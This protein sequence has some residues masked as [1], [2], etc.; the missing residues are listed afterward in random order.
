MKQTLCK[1]VIVI[2]CI[3]VSSLIFAKEISCTNAI[4]SFDSLIC[5][6]PALLKLDKQLAQRYSNLL[7]ELPT[8][9]KKIK[10]D[11]YTW[12]KIRNQCATEDCL[13]QSYQE[14]IYIVNLTLR[15]AHAHKPNTQD[16]Q[17][18]ESLRQAILLQAKKHPE[19][20]LEL[21][22]KQFEIK[23]GL[24]TFSNVYPK[25]EHYTAIH[26]TKR[27]KDVSK[28]E[29][30]A[31]VKS[32]V[33][34]GGENGVGSY[35]LLDVNGD[36]ARDLILNSYTGGTGLFSEI[37]AFARKGD[38]FSGHYINMYKS[39][40][41]TSFENT[42]LATEDASYLYSLNGRGSNQS[43]FWIKFQNQVY[44]AYVNGQYGSTTVSLL[45]PLEINNRVPA[46]VVSY[47]YQL[48]IPEKQVSADHATRTLTKAELEAL[49]KA[50][51]FVDPQHIKDNVVYEGLNAKP[52]CPVPA[53]S[54]EDE[55]LDYYS[56][57]PGHYAFEIV[58]DIPVY[59]NDACYLGQLVNWFGSYSEK[60]GLYAL[61]WMRK[62][63]ENEFANPPLE[64][65]VYGKRKMISV[66]KMEITFSENN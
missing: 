33:D 16:F 10:Q 60:D 53:N 8:E 32:N 37:S 21:A 24:T 15:N 43:A 20:S 3:T 17:A 61:L 52:I 12:L 56:Y 1:T 29:W 31:F 64:F 2:A 23:K 9:T 44:V 18:L 46:L 25:D 5:N 41:D 6:S 36:G 54:T 65:S 63:G 55:K 19:F 4:T 49:N 59:L 13:N 27:P 30:N 14:R 22:L 40:E 66:K 45:R 62:P 51:T 47:Q 35:T 39:S 42:S 28:D 26:P 7:I 57:G 58:A 48:S 34:A 38:Y 11:Q 50:L